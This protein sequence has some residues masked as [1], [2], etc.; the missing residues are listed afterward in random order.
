MTGKIARRSVENSYKSIIAWIIQNIKLEWGDYNV[1]REELKRQLALIDSTLAFISADI[2]R[3]QNH[4]DVY[5]N[6]NLI[7]IEKEMNAV[8]GNLALQAKNAQ[9]LI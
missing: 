1:T 2:W 5:N 8:M 9:L 6:D 4:Y 7:K 3:I